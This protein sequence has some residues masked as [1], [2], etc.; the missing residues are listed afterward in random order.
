MF[1]VAIVITL[2]VFLELMWNSTLLIRY[3]LNRLRPPRVNQFDIRAL[4]F[5]GYV[6]Y[7]QLDKMVYIDTGKPCPPVVNRCHS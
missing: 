4:L 2:S 6:R 1:Y 3:N 5:F 7:I